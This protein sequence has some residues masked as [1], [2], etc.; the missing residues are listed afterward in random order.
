MVM[1]L[2]DWRLVG[3]G[4]RCFPRQHDP[5][6]HETYG[7]QRAI[8]NPI[9]A[10]LASG[11]LLIDMATQSATM[12][13]VPVWFTARE[14]Q[15]LMH[16]ARNANQW[17]TAEEIKQAIWGGFRERQEGKT[18]RV[19][20]ARMRAKLGVASAVILNRP[21]FGYMLRPDDA[22]GIAPPAALASIASRRWAKDQDACTWCKR[23]DRAHSGRGLC[24]TCYGRQKHA[25]KFS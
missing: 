15:V 2:N 22:P 12:N 1:Q 17:C 9:P 4:D 11:G 5:E 18:V 23:S 21:C 19:N 20:I 3:C 13:G 25:G 7:Y 14:W 6:T 24:T 8:E 16:L 10:V